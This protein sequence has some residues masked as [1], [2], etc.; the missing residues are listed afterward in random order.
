[1]EVKFS[2]SVSTE[3]NEREGILSAQV[4]PLLNSIPRVEEGE[5]AEVFQVFVL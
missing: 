2:E 1:M 3:A 5:V 4:A